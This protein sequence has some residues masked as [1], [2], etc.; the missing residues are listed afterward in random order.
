MNVILEKDGTQI[1]YK[2]GPAIYLCFSFLPAIGG[3]IALALMIIRKQFRGVFVNQF[4]VVVALS[5]LFR[6]VI[7]TG[8]GLLVTLAYIFAL[9]LSIY[10]TVMYV[11]NANYYSI[12][13]RL[14][15]GY[16]VVNGDE[17]VVAEAVS[18]AQNIKKQF[19]Q[20]TKF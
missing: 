5:L 2:A 8:S 10:I 9:V 20:I 13:Q 17:P 7:L 1:E 15:E 6:I 12:K 3:L 18:R 19:W 11:L 4:I 16:T 14:D